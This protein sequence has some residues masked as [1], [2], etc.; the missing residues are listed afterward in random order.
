MRKYP[1]IFN[2]LGILAVSV[3]LNSNVFAGD[4]EWSGVYRLEGYSLK[5]SEMRGSR[6]RE[7]NYG[8]SHLV[9]RPKITAGDG[10]TIYG[11]FD[12]FNNADY[13]NSQMGQVWG[14]GVR[15]GAA[16]ATTSSDNSNA[17]SRTQ[18]AET[19]EVSQLYLTYSHEYGQAIAG[20]AP[21]HFGLG[22]THNAGRGLFD[23]FYDTRDLVGYK[24]VVGNFYVLPMFGKPSEGAIGRSDDVND[25]MI[26]A[27][28]E[29]PES[30]I[31]MGV[32]Y[33]L[34]K[35]GD[36]G[37]D[38]PAPGGADGL[39]GGPGATQSAGI[40]SRMVNIFALRDNERFRLGL[41][42]SF[43]SGENG[44][45]DANGGKVSWGGFGIATEAEYRPEG[46]AWRWGLKAGT[47]SGDDPASTSKFE[48]FSF[49]RNYD[50]AMLMFNHPLGQADLFRTRPVH[51][52]DVRDAD[53]NITKADVEA[54][55]N[56]LYV[57]PTAR[58]AFNDKWSLD[59][60]IVT[61][62]MNSNSVPGKS[63]SKDLGYEW[64]AAIVFSPRKGVAWVNQMGLLFPG[65]AWKVDGTYDNKFVMGFASKAAISF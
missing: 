27:Q 33:Q 51:G 24:F 36:Q 37:S 56:V 43:M 29:N 22:M 3:F 10:L 55:S 40:N 20:R 53:G 62:W 35:S 52:A 49:S 1:V 38:A 13:P 48:G 25:Y 2:T 44:V 58:Y 39:Y 4:I 46:S 50:V 6:K 30:D 7:L 64:D 11:Q 5:N 63:V 60:T 17:T 54:I 8:L 65:S 28:F 16:N 12:V 15:T 14:S 18:K 61:G 57:A 42:A 45:A 41:E 19:L 23:H 32:F 31:E 26:Q 47:A 34:R 9:L 21:I 59:N